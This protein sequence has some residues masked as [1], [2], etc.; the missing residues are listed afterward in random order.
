[1]KFPEI[2]KGSDRLGENI[3]EMIHYIA[4]TEAAKIALRKQLQYVKDID[5]SGCYDLAD[6]YFR[7]KR[8]LAQ[9]LLEEW[10]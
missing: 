4:E 7:G 1:M 2:P 6:P 8:D 10:L 5:E 9:E 3:Q